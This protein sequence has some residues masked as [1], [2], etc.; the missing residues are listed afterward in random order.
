[1]D[2]STP[3]VYIREVDSGAKP[4]ASVATSIPGFL[5]LFPFSPPTDA[6]A[7]TGNDGSKQITGK[8]L[9][10]LVDKQGNIK[11]D[12]AEAAAVLRDTF[13]R[14]STDVKDLGKFLKL[15][16]KTLGGKSG[17]TIKKDGDSVSVSLGKKSLSVPGSVL[18]A[19]GTISG[20]DAAVND[21][22]SNLQL[23]I[24]VQPERAW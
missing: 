17:V 3:G 21:L 10:A 20:D 1:M 8:V 16:G 22:L 24:R 13:K 6:I 2:Y 14:K 15:H 4:I 11:G 9:P 7:I 23:R 5:G 12:A 18:A 19:D